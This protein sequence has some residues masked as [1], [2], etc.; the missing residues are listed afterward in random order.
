MVITSSTE[1]QHFT[2]GGSKLRRSR[3]L[4]STRGLAP[5]NIKDSKPSDRLKPDLNQKLGLCPI[6][7]RTVVDDKESK[8]RHHMNWEL[9]EKI[10]LSSGSSPG[11]EIRPDIKNG[12]EFSENRRKTDYETTCKS[13][14]FKT[15]G[16]VRTVRKTDLGLMNVSGFPANENV[17]KSDS[18]YDEAVSND[19]SI[20]RKGSQRKVVGGVKFEKSLK[21]KEKVMTT[22]Q[23]RWVAAK[24]RVDKTNESISKRL[25]LIHELNQK[26]LANYERFHRKNTRTHLKELRD[27]EEVLED[28][29]EIEGNAKSL[30]DFEEDPK[31]CEETYSKIVH[32]RK[33]RC[34]EHRPDEEELGKKK[35]DISKF[36]FSKD[37]CERLLSTQK[38]YIKSSRESSDNFSLAAKPEFRQNK[39]DMSFDEKNA[40]RSV[41]Y[42]QNNYSNEEGKE[43]DVRSEDDLLESSRL[44]PENGI[45]FR[46]SFRNELKIL[47]TSVDQRRSKEECVQIKDSTLRAAK[48]KQAE[49]S[50]S[51]KP[52]DSMNLSKVSTQEKILEDEI[53]KNF[54]DTIGRFDTEKTNYTCSSDSAG[55][56]ESFSTDSIQS[57][58]PASSSKSPANATFEETFNSSWDSGVGVEV[59]S[60]SGWVRVHTGIES[61]LIYLTFDT[62]SKDVCRDMLLGDE[63]SLF[64]QVR[65]LFMF[66]Y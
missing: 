49:E 31:D 66:L 46:S 58:T 10:S 43:D 3:R 59:G 56:S 53:L 36:T 32:K 47:D 15:K 22:T 14:D 63:L 16:S 20:L 25:E 35:L 13:N 33:S 28:S 45:N 6:V 61:S 52:K 48:I 2:E 9:N 54:N 4:S 44:Y 18:K 24:E 34:F 1:K 26:I 30:L 60:G 7:S 27:C 55:K 40:S 62:T 12:I 5:R 38:T 21:T 39:R 65:I 19:S 50:H 64:I 29:F 17:I 42:I 51:K 37:Y 23:K 41:F 11:I 57:V 8:R